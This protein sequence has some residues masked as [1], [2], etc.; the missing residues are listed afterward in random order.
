MFIWSTLSGYLYP[1][2]KS[3]QELRDLE[4][5][6]EAETVEEHRWLKHIQF[7]FSYRPAPPA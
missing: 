3:G 1:W 4:A 6:T 2:E 5:E 7:A